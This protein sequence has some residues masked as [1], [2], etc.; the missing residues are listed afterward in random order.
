[1]CL[2]VPR[3]IYEWLN[4]R[5]PAEVVVLAGLYRVAIVVAPNRSVCFILPVRFP[6]PLSPQLTSRDDLHNVRDIQCYCR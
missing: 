5:C 4:R 6:S 1:M 2:D 3:V